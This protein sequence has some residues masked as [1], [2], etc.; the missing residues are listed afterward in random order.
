M[1]SLDKTRLTDNLTTYHDMNSDNYNDF[2]AM[3]HEGD[4][5][6]EWSIAMIDEQGGQTQVYV[7]EAGFA[8]SQIETALRKKFESVT[9]LTGTPKPADETASRAV[10]VKLIK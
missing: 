2:A 5:I 4:N 6:Y 1:I 8:I 3:A 7:T 9:L 10:Y